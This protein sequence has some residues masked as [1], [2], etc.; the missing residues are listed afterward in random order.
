MDHANA[1]VPPW[2]SFWGLFPRG[3]DT[4]AAVNGI[5]FVSFPQNT[6]NLPPHC[7]LPASGHTNVVSSALTC[8][9]FLFLKVL[10]SQWEEVKGTP[11]AAN[12]METWVKEHLIGG[13]SSA[14]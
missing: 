6:Y 3:S 12:S 8:E 11:S 1:D 2:A 9:R 13:L 10:H 4:L 7:V 5:I 14:H